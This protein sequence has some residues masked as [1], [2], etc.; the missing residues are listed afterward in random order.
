[1]QSPPFTERGKLRILFDG[2][3]VTYDIPRSLCKKI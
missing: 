1:V 2:S 3:S